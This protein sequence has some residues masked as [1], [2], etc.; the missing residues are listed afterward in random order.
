LGRIATIV[1]FN[2]H[3]IALNTNSFASYLCAC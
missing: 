3:T 1:V 2:Q